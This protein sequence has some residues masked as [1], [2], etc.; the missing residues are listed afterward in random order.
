MI[1][2]VLNRVVDNTLDARLVNSI[3]NETGIKSIFIRK[4]KF[5]NKHMFPLGN[6]IKITN[7]LHK[8]DKQ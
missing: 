2:N 5:K 6:G 4:Y 8:Y 1:N 7:A 3:I